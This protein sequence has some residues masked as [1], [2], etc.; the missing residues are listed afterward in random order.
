MAGNIDYSSLR[1]LA[2]FRKG[3]AAFAQVDTAHIQIEMWKTSKV[4]IELYSLERKTTIS[5]ERKIDVIHGQSQSLCL[6]DLS[7]ED[8]CRFSDL[9]PC[10]D[11]LAQRQE[12]VPV[13]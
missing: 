9:L 12:Q 7:V 11:G 13:L 1:G 3:Q 6:V 10:R 8:G 5:V 4:I 2:S